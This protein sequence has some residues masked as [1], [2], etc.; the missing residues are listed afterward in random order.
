MTSV[1]LTAC[2]APDDGSIDERDGVSLAAWPVV[3]TKTER[4]LE[5][6]D[7]LT[8]RSSPASLDKLSPAKNDARGWVR[9]AL[10][11]PWSTGPV[12]DTTGA[13][14]AMGQEGPIWY[15]AGTS[16]GPVTRE[17]TIPAGKKIVLPL[18]NSWWTFPEEFYPDE[19]SI[20][21]G[22]PES[23]A[24][25]EDNFAHTCSLTLRIDGED[26]VAGGDFDGMVEALYVETFEPFEIDLHPSDHFMTQYGVA[27]GP[28]LTTGAG[29][30]ARLKKLTPG[31]HVLEFGAS[32]CEGEELWFETS[33]TYQLHIV[34]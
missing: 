29:F 13:S 1:W 16:G 19:E 30:Y 9:W 26:V 17:C 7:E 20:E 8:F 25:L 23:I 15:L 5:P 28:M 33:A 31:D 2:D 3:E 6:S 21:E 12:N 32:L 14:C 4:A 22:I 11:L 27:G 18:V 34:P 10:S 24:W